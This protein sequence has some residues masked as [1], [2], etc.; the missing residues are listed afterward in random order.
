MDRYLRFLYAQPDHR[1][2]EFI[3]SVLPVDGDLAADPFSID[4]PDVLLKEAFV[5][6]DVF[7]EIEHR[8]WRIILGEPGTGK[9]AL[10]KVLACSELALNPLKVTTDSRYATAASPSELVKDGRY[11]FRVMIDL[12]D[13]TAAPSDPTATKGEWSFLSSPEVWKRIFAEYWERAIVDPT[14]RKNVL[15]RLRTNRRWVEMVRWFYNECSPLHS[16]IE[17][18]FEFMVWLRVPIEYR[19]PFFD[20]HLSEPLRALI[21]MITQEPVV[22]KLGIAQNRG[23]PIPKCEILIDGVE[24][25]PEVRVQRLLEDFRRMYDWGNK[26]LSAKLF[27]GQARWDQV[28][29][30]LGRDIA[31]TFIPRWESDELKKVLRRRLLL[32]KRGEPVSDLLTR[33]DLSLDTLMRRRIKGF[34]RGELEDTIVKSAR[35]SPLHALRLARLAIALGLELEAKGEQMGPESLDKLIKT[36]YDHIE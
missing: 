1:Y 13:V 5:G 32:F 12:H 16:L 18:E 8:G 3:K 6:R 26:A 21:D 22:G 24:Q 20:L 33:H 4:L 17:D 36:Y 7:S 10:C 19:E 29:R 23:A 35:N 25:L 31:V 9:S 34:N 11:I 2:W 27:I 15:H 28:R 30:I 14:G